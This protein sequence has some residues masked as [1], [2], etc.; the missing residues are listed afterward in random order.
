MIFYGTAITLALRHGVINVL[1][2]SNIEEGDMRKSIAESIILFFSLRNKNQIGNRL[3]SSNST[4][5]LSKNRLYLYIGLFNTVLLMVLFK[6][7]RFKTIIYY[8]IIVG[9]IYMIC[10]VFDLLYY[11][12]YFYKRKLIRLLIYLITYVG[13]SY[14]N[15]KLL[16][17]M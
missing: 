1:G 7:C 15:K 9:F 11:Y 8:Y 5:N 13:I 2:N 3:F 6:Y 10:L 12:Y 4:I 14:V 16:L 17:V